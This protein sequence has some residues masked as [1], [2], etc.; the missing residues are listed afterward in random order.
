MS[1]WDV[2]ARS[3][4]RASG[5]HADSRPLALLRRGS[6]LSK[7]ITELILI[8]AAPT[9]GGGMP[10]ALSAARKTAEGSRQHPRDMEVEGRLAAGIAHD[11]N[12]HLTGTLAALSVME[13]RIGQD[14]TDELPRYLSIA[15]VA[16]RHAA[17]L[18]RC[19]LALAQ[20]RS[21]D[22]MGVDVNG[23]IA[24]LEDM[25]RFILGPGVS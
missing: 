18:T 4:P 13:R 25:P 2:R 11:A 24:S 12:N 10:D 19:L 8:A 21:P 15:A 1:S 9:R 22:A 20:L 14:R 3:W 7:D 5:S 6:T 17:A 16:A 23:L